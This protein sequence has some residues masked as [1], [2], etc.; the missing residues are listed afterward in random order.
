MSN[1]KQGILVIASRLLGY[2]SNL[3]MEEMKELISLAEEAFESDEVKKEFN[4][5]YSSFKDKE[6]KEI[7]EMYVATFDLKAKTGMYLTAHELGDSNK[8]GA[9]LIKLQKIIN[10]AGFERVD[11]ELVDYIPMLLEFLSIAPEIKEKERLEY[12]MAIALERIRKNLEEETPYAKII[13]ILMNRVFPNPS[14]EEIEQ[15]E[16]NREEADLEELPYPIMYQ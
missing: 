4:E 11:E 2:P 1:D 10:Q 16:N 12:R 9:A 3:F 7:Q 14:R 5:V 13:R 8:R 6:I 15:L